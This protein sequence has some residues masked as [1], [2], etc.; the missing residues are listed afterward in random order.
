[1]QR[2]SSEILHTGMARFAA[3]YFLYAVS[4]SPT[5]GWGDALFLNERRV[6][7]QFLALYVGYC[8]VISGEAYDQQ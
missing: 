5:L 1:M 8:G 7:V 2:S 3:L 6:F 4:R